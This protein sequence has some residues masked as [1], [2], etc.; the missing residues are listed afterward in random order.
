MDGA[1]TWVLQGY[2][3]MMRTNYKGGAHTTGNLEVNPGVLPP[4]VIRVRQRHSL[5]SR[6]A[7]QSPL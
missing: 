5:T 4:P 7:A 6:L 2:Q 1:V 3:E